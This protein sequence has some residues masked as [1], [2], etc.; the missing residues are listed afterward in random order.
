MMD[1]IDG[2]DADNLCSLLCSVSKLFVVAADGIS[3]I[4]C[5]RDDSNE[6]TNEL[7]PVLPHELCRIDMRQFVKLLQNHCEHLFPFFG[8]DGTARSLLSSSVH[9][10]TSGC[11][12][13]QSRKILARMLGLSKDGVLQ[14]IGIRC[15]K[16]FVE[17]WRLLLLT[18]LQ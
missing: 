16:S 6:A 17:D 14:T 15:C 5:E 13:K 11:L 12:E 8:A 7:P 1:Q 3:Q 10:E 2:L 18:L 9:F 4:V